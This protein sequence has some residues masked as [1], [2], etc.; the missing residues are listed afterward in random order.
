ILASASTSDRVVTLSQLITSDSSLAAEVASIM[1]LAVLGILI[2][3]VLIYNGLVSL[4]NE[5]DR[6]FSNVD[7]LL[8]QRFDLIP[9]LVSVCKAYMEHESSVIQA[10]SASRGQWSDARGRVEKLN[11]AAVLI[12]PLRQLLATAENY[13]RLRANE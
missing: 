9:N 12:P 5:V 13:P 6:A 3:T 11:A 10:V 8:Q 2:Y 7:V 4:R 1:A